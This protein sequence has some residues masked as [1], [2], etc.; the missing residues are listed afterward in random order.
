MRATLVTGMPSRMVRSSGWSL[1]V[2][3]RI[4]RRLRLLC[5]VVTSILYE[6]WPIPQSAAADRW[7]STASGP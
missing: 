6:P 5:G 2:W 3:A 1:A 4:F 7:L